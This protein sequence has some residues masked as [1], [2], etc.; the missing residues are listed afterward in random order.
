MKRAWVIALEYSVWSAAWAA[1]AS[2]V[3]AQS[4]SSDGAAAYFVWAVSFPMLVQALLVW[5]LTRTAPALAS[6]FDA[7]STIYNSPTDPS[8]HLPAVLLSLLLPI[9]PMIIATAA[10]S[11][12]FPA[13]HRWLTA[14]DTVQQQVA[15]PWQVCSL[16]FGMTSLCLVWPFLGLAQYSEESA[17]I[18]YETAIPP[19]I[20]EPTFSDF[21]RD[22]LWLLLFVG[23]P[24]MA[25]P[26]LPVL[27]RR[28]LIATWWRWQT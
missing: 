27:L 24:F 8:F 15:R 10:F 5:G 17:R 7:L 19:V 2:V 26:L 23:I 22:I 11:H 18:G 9:L 13:I 16:A 3:Q 12:V 25:G 6:Y 20:D 1:G 21:L 28:G 14:G 4:P